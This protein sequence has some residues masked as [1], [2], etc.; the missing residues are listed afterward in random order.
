[1]RLRML[2]AAIIATFVYAPFVASAATKIDDPAKFVT[3]VYAKMAAPN[4]SYAAPEDIN[5]PR[6]DSLFALEK[7]ESGGE[8]GRLDFDFWT[9][10][11]D[12][13]LSGVSVKEQ[14][15]EG[16]DA[17]KVV[18]A[19]FKNSGTPEEIHFYFE[20]TGTGW[21]LDDVR[22]LKGEPWTLSLILKYGWD[23]GN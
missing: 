19:K 5:T 11:Q 22:S 1:M 10:A 6:L 3:A 4:S 18:I 15:V 23:T 14:P 16:S 13:Q 9:N 12:L 7:K 2:V 17:R 21:K 8:V 20:R